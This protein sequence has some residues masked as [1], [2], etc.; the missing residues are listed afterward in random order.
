[1]GTT[2]LKIPKAAVSMQEG[3]I[4]EWLVPDGAA[5]QEGQPL[6]NLEIEKSIM[7][8]EAPASG[9]LRQTAAAGEAYPV[10]HE[11]GEIVSE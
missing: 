4:A 6:Y 7:E 11:I 1:M 8:V 10:G 5:V 2:V 3:T 9:V